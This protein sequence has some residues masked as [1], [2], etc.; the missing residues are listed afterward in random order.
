M[1]NKMLED[2]LRE[3]RS[4]LGLKQNEV[5]ELV[6]VTPQ[7]YLKWE[8]GK[9]E[10]KISQA[11]KLARALKVSEK[12][13]CQGEFHKQKMEPI[14]FIRRVETLLQNVPHSEFLIGMQEYIHDE[15][16]FIEMLKEASDYPYELFDYED[17]HKAEQMIELANSGAIKFPDEKQKQDFIDHQSRII[18]KKRA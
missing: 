13:L 8:N 14:E 2:V 11:G 7:T 4:K 16:G 17:I 10:P 3:A 5:A 6:G 18:K 15:D 9:S 1:A 12:E